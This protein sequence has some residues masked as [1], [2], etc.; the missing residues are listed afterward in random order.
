MIY[1]QSLQW[2][3]KSENI[4][5]KK[6]KKNL[7]LS[8]NHGLINCNLSDEDEIN[9]SNHLY[10]NKKKI[11]KNDLKKVNL[12]IISG[13]NISFM[14]RSIF[15]N[16]LRNYTYVNVNLFEKYNLFDS[17]ISYEKRRKNFSEKIINFLA[18][19]TLDLIEFK[20]NQSTSNYLKNL[21]KILQELSKENNTI[22]VQN[23]INY[24]NLN[25]INKINKEILK[26]SKKYRLI[27]FDI[28]KYSKF[29]GSNKWFDKAKYKFAKIPMSL[30][31]LNF[32]TYKL[33]RLINII[34]GGT[35]KVLV[36]DLDNTLWGG[37][38]GD[39]GIKKIKIGRKDKVSKSFL[40][41]QKFIKK[42]KSK[43][44]LLAVCSKNL[45][46]TTQ[47][48]FK[49]K[50][51]PLKLSD[52]VAFK[53]NW[54]DKATNINKISKELNLSTDSF[55]FFDDNPM[56][57]DIVRKN[58]SGISVPEIDNDPS[59]YIR[60]LAVP[61][62]FDA[63]SYSKEDAQRTQTYKSNIK[64]NNLLKKSINVES[65]LRSLNMKSNMSQ[66]KIKNID[67][68]TQLFL[69]SN[70]FNLTTKRYQKKD[71]INFIK[72]KNNYTLQADLSD[73]FGQNGIVSLLAGSFI[74]DTLIIENWVM[75]C[76]VLSRTLEQAI[77]KKIIYDL[78]KI[79]INKIIGIYKHSS[80]NKIVINH[81][82][83]LKFIMQKKT[84]E[85]TS[86]ELNLNNFNVDKNKNFIK[87]F[88]G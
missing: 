33:S 85:K 55:V 5:I 58:I 77:L 29:I 80:R 23:L 81:Y 22:I 50:K 38:I 65:Y 32:Y 43:G 25:Y 56:E 79:N 62:Y 47:D 66:F 16:C 17:F 9:L 74:K 24:K 2:L 88:N 78:K 21:E 7:R 83:N 64:R 31:N 44:V 52:F 75:S 34:L 73:K 35:K 12:N 30:E 1:Y 15:L 69:R 49:K 42:L 37:I 46:K 61:G 4:I 68:I 40:N 51:M 63:L 6:I 71:I 20:K 48:A 8:L 59:N 60:D 26:F 84:K 27:I 45:E 67:R 72:N 70:Q 13:S 54:D 28:N 11:E 76:R 36:L 14:V 41:F 82:K 87:I 53:S 86:W 57:R 18:L 19:D 39:D 3:P 10:Q